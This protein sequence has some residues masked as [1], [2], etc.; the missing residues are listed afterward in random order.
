[1]EFHIFIIFVVMASSHASI[2]RGLPVESEMC[3]NTL[4]Q[5]N[6]DRKAFATAVGHGTHSL[7]LEPLRFFGY[8]CY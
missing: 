8:G 4:A 1:M 6:I 3:L 7:Y 5:E 2:L